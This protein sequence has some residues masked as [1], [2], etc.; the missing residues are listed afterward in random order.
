MEALADAPSL[1]DRLLDSA[2]VRSTIFCRSTMRAPWG[3]AVAAHGNPAFHFVSK[4]SC[5]LEVEGHGDRKLGAGD[6]VVLPRGPEHAL[7]DAPG[8]PTLW[9][10]EILADTP[11]DANGRLRHGG[12]GPLTELVCG[13]FALD[14][15]TPRSLIEALPEVI[16]VRASDGAAAPWVAAT[17]ELAGSA[18]ESA[19]AGS[20][21]VLTRV[22]D[23]LLAQALR[24]GLADVDAGRLAALRDPHVARAVQLIHD[25]PARRWSVSELAHAVGYSRSSFASHFRELVGESPIAYATRTRLAFAAS[26]LERPDA[27]VGEVA[28]GVG[29]ASESAFSRAFTHA[30]GVRPGAYR[31]RTV[32]PRTSPRTDE[33]RSK[34]AAPRSSR[35]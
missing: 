9:L 14:A 1:A 17:L 27:S 4:G 21:A 20:A 35:S 15:R 32:D 23:A 5:R 16:H 11:P 26:E 25:N 31:V 30:F 8:S 19:A 34:P 18:A 22:S 13:G 6:L 2:R 33:R 28:R 10:D 12:Q 29:Y 7:R 24:F 3:F